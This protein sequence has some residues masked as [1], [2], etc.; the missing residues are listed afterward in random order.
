MKITLSAKWITL[1]GIF[2][3]WS[4][5]WG[6]RPYISPSGVFN[7]VLGIAPNLL[8]SFCL[9]FGAEWLLPKK[10][11]AFE[12]NFSLVRLLFLFFIL[13]CANEFLQLIPFFGRTFDIMDILCSA[14]GL[15]A[16]YL[17]YVRNHK[18]VV[19]VV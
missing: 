4:I 11:A 17:V 2:T 16:S 1:I 5:K 8:G 14:V 12:R 15:Y 6:I 10:L 18:S 7:Y 13:L 9:L 19:I 3:I